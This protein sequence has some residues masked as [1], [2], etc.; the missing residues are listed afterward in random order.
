MYM[1][2]GLKKYASILIKKK[3]HWEFLFVVRFCCIK[4][5]FSK[6]SYTIQIQAIDGRV[7]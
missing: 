5:I 1:Y 2:V 4:Q 3:L 7:T 6:G